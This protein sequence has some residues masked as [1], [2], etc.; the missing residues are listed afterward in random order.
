MYIILVEMLKLQKDTNYQITQE[1]TENLSGSIISKNIFLVIRK[2]HAKKIAN[3]DVFTGAFYQTYK[4]ELIPILHKFFQ[5]IKRNEHFP[6]HSIFQYFTDSKTRR[7][8]KKIKLQ[9]NMPYK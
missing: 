1:K 3:P 7:Y 2:L 5:K 8:H 4:A 6:T 9:V